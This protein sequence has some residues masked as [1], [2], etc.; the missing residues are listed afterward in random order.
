MWWNGIL[1]IP[2]TSIVFPGLHEIAHVVSVARLVSCCVRV[3]WLRFLMDSPSCF[4]RIDVLLFDMSTRNHYCPVSTLPKYRKSALGATSNK[5]YRKNQVTFLWQLDQQQ[6]PPPLLPLLEQAQV[7]L[8]EHAW[9]AGLA[10]HQLSLKENIQI[11][12]WKQD[13]QMLTTVKTWRGNDG[14]AFA[15]RVSQGR[16][17]FSFTKTT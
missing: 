7:S 3:S 16:V 15:C 9:V 4:W 2:Q 11:V 17:M 14:L 6:Q 12:H 5:I 1:G 8:H 10:C 13:K